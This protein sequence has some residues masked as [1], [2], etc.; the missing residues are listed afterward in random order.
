M[1]SL[2][3]ECKKNWEKMYSKLRAELEEKTA[4]IEELENT[5]NAGSQK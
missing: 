5:L 4:F 3:F 1:S 2:F